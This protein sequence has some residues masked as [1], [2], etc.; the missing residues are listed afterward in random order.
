MDT[1]A[2]RPRLM[3][4]IRK[5]GRYL[6]ESFTPLNTSRHASIGSKSIG[7]INIDCQFLFKS[8]RWGVLG[9]E[10]KLPAGI[11]Y[12][13]LNLGPPQGCRVK[14][15]TITITLDEEAT[16]LKRYQE[17]RTFHESG[18]PVQMTDW[19]GPK[20]LAGQNKTAYIHRTTKLTPEANVLGNG[21]GGVG[22][23]SNKAYT[24]SARWSFNGQLLPG[25][26]KK[27]RALCKSLRWDLN[28]NE[29]ESQS[30]HS[31]K[32]STAF[33]FQHS[34]Q[35]FLLKVDI[36]GKL[37]KWNDRIK[38]K[39]KF[40]TTLEKEGKVVTLVDFE[41]YTRFK[42]VLDPVAESLPWAMEMQN[43]QD[44]PVVVPDFIPGTV[45]QATQASPHTDYPPR[46]P[47]LNNS[48]PLQG[49]TL[50]GRPPLITHDN[51]MLSQQAATPASNE[52]TLRAQEVMRA[53]SELES[54]DTY[55][56]L[57]EDCPPSSSSTTVV[58]SNG[59]EPGTETTE[60]PKPQ[61]SR[62]N[63]ELIFRRTADDEALARV[64]DLPVIVMFLR[65][66]A[67]LMRLMGKDRRLE[68]RSE[69][70]A[71][72]LPVDHQHESS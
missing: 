17:G 48:T 38:S 49:L 1:Q 32:V 50:T 70:A 10:E 71:D 72:I 23:E 11:I 4:G 67:T 43:F 18:C 2:H 64:I 54:P 45:F 59:D 28:E 44:I 65:L 12:L 51:Q 16:C 58:S 36:D 30:F 66:L 14:S 56:I 46:N 13:N 34:G 19:Y 47:A 35:P 5:Y 25:S 9:R 60:T 31:S 55:K 42:Q 29:L 37:E 24:R 39:F 57:P 68:E 41:D 6:D 3:S 63:A 61:V 26:G 40:G 52:I 15:A 69:L 21:G 62:T 7:K 53:L 33:T 8:S 22:F 27:N 20:A